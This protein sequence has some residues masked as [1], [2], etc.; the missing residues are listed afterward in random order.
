V[1]LKYLATFDL[2]RTEMQANFALG[3]PR[4]HGHPQTTFLS[5]KA[6]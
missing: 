1:R 2:R 4:R 6:F 3:S 5:A